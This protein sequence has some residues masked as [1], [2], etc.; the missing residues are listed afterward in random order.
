MSVALGEVADV[1]LVEI[2]V[3]GGPQQLLGEVG[4]DG[5]RPGDRD[6]GTDGESERETRQRERDGEIRTGRVRRR[7]N[8]LHILS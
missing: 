1:V 4:Q 6:R 7:V 3:E 5:C 8:R 2:L